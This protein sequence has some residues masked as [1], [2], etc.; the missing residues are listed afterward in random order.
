MTYS[1]F[2]GR[3]GKM[4]GII[5]APQAAYRFAFIS[6]LAGPPNESIDRALKSKAAQS[7]CF[8]LA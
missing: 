3:R 2:S 4:V 7:Y 1:S 8:F 6:H 5:C